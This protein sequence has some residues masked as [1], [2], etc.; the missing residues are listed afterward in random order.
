MKMENGMVNSSFWRHTAA[1]FSGGS[2]EMLDMSHLFIQQSLLT[3]QYF[4]FK[5]KFVLAYSNILSNE[6][7]KL[8]Y[9]N[10]YD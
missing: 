6:F 5:L 3:N 7:T 9:V 2:R 4:K 1:Q 10:D 8:I